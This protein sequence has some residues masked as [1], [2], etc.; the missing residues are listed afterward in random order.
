M[1][2]VW[3]C[4]LIKTKRQGLPIII[5]HDPVDEDI[6]GL[7]DEAKEQ[8]I[9]LV[10]DMDQDV[11]MLFEDDDEFEDIDL[12]GFDEEDVW[13]VNKEWLIAPVTPPLMLVV[14]PPSIYETGPWCPTKCVVGYLIRDNFLVLV[15]M[16]YLLMEHPGQWKLTQ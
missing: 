11:A 5:L 3:C 14:P 7:V 2:L 13:E 10:A 8:M 15:S 12:D 9:A 6:V 1:A 16:E 4:F